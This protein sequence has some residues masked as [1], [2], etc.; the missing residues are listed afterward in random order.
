[1]P[2]HYLQGT[3][4]LF[5]CSEEDR[6]AHRWGLSPA[7]CVTGEREAQQ[8]SQEFLLVTEAAEAEV[9]G[10]KPGLQ[11][12]PT[13]TRCLS[14]PGLSLL[15]CPLCP[16]PAVPS[17]GQ[18]LLLLAAQSALLPASEAP[19]REAPSAL[20][21]P[22]RGKRGCAAAFDPE[23]TLPRTRGERPPGRPSPAGPR[24][25]RRRP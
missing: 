16:T 5:V 8:R 14:A 12:T 20:A 18:R 11:P 2:P 17:A 22:A 25:S 23:L 1:M 7:T 10:K 6:P 3:D 24:G 15:L 4:R 9:A 13:A 19:L 21:D